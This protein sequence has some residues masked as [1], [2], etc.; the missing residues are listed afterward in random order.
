LK[1]RLQKFEQRVIEVATLKETVRELK[2]LMQG[3][4]AERF[5]AD[6]TGVRAR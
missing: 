5:S 1:S 3:M 6:K 4:N 2:E